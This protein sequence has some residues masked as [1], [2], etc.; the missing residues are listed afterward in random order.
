MNC[1]N[2]INAAVISLNEK[3]KIYNEDIA[4]CEECAEC[5]TENCKKQ[6]VNRVYHTVGCDDNP[7]HLYTDKCEEHSFIKEDCPCSKTVRDVEIKPFV[8]V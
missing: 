3:D 5:S 8:K 2:C 4:W 7:F 1:F 6:I